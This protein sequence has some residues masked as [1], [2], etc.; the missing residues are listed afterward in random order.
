MTRDGLSVVLSRRNPLDVGVRPWLGDLA[1]HLV[2]Q[3][4]ASLFWAHFTAL[5]AQFFYQIPFLVQGL[6]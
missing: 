5:S 3:M 6:V 1:P 4:V 2:G